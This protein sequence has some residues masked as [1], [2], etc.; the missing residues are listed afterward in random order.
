MDSAAVEPVADGGDLPTVLDLQLDAAIAEIV[1]LAEGSDVSAPAAEPVMIAG[2]FSQNDVLAA[3]PASFAFPI[4][5]MPPSSSAEA[6]PTIPKRTLAKASPPPE[7][8]MS[9]ASPPPLSPVMDMDITILGVP[10]PSS[11]SKA[12]ALGSGSAKSSLP[13]VAP[14]GIG[15]YMRK[16]TSL[17]AAPPP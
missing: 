1:G 9:L 13:A 17:K 12:A 8:A 14:K 16:A 3:I 15:Q 4:S 6:V 11:V 5:M 7:S 2:E 10:P